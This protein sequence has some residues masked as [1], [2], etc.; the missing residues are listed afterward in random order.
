MIEAPF[1]LKEVRGVE[2]P[3]IP[4]NEIVPVLPAVKLNVCPLSIVLENEMGAPAAKPLVVLIP[5]A[6]P[7]RTG[8]VIVTIPPLVVKEPVKL[9]EV[10]P[11]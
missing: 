11:V 2:P 7:R 9:I 6:D 10:D 1:A 3:T 4:L 8:P 5:M